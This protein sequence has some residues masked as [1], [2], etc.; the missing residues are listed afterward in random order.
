MQPVS[1]TRLREV[2]EYDADTGVLVWLARLGQPAFN[3]RFAGKRALASVHN[4][5]YLWGS[6]DGKLVMAHRVAWALQSGSWPSG[7]ID[8]INGNRSD[9]RI[10]N[11]RNVSAFEN[12]R[13]QAVPKNNTSGFIGVSFHKQTGKWASGIRVNG[14]R[15]HLGLFDCPTAASFAYKRAAVSH[16]FHENHGRAA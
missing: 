3:A 9:N 15:L 16:G 6:V 14:R 8:H 5:G 13:N 11:L 4:D 12:S 10:E 1:I 7:Q 2:L